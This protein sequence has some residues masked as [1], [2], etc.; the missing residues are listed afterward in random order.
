MFANVSRMKKVQVNIVNKMLLV[1]KFSA[2]HHKASESPA[3]ELLL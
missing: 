1:T 3:Q 2:L